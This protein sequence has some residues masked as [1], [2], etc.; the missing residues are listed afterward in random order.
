MNVL[1]I[2]NTIPEYRIN[3]FKLLSGQ[4]NLSILITD[5]NLANSIYGLSFNKDDTLRIKLAESPKSIKE[6]IDKGNFDV[7]VLP[8]IDTL[9]QFRCAYVALE[10]C[11]KRNIKTVYWSEKWE[12]L[13]EYQPYPKRL[14]NFIHSWMIS[15]FARRV[16]L[17]VAAGT[18]SKEYLMAHGVSIEKMA[19]AYDSS[20]SPLALKPISLYEMYNIPQNAPIVLYLGRLI[21]RKGLK[22]LI[23]AFEHILKDFPTAYLLIGG[24]GEIL[25]GCKKLAESRNMK[26]VIFAG[27]IEPS[28]RR[29]YYSQSKVFVLPSYSYKG[30]IEAWGLTVNEALEQGTPVVATTAVGAAYDVANGQECVMISENNEAELAT[31]I[32][33]MLAKDISHLACKSLYAKYSVDNM[34]N[35]FASALFKFL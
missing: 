22:T 35:L 15:Y 5:I 33:N 1:F 13:K 23:R 21:E 3:F 18:K 34:A 7:V 24:T 11:T 27:K 6:T 16:D 2:H 32:E 25:D 8:S 20:T 31:A 17:C 4:V 29:E 10:T 14:K 30:I 9:Y 26:H 19:I 28:V 12:A